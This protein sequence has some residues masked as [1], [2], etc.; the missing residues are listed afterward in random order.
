M[1]MSPKGRT[2][3]SM[4]DAAQTSPR[5]TMSPH[6]PFILAHDISG[7]ILQPVIITYNAL[8]MVI[9]V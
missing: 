5:L 7:G 1:S 2:K 9:V 4:V 6:F 3:P 8:L